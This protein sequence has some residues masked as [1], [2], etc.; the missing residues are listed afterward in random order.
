MTAPTAVSPDGARLS[1]GLLLLA[2]AL[3]PA[4]PSG[5]A[6]G[7]PLRGA[8]GLPCPLCGMTRSVVATVHGNV[9]EALATNPAGVLLVVLAVTVLLAR[10]RPRLR[11]PP[12]AL[13]AAAGALWLWQ[14]ARF[15][16]T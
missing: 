11:L 7:C 13:P 2:G 12:W 1:A 5:L 9:G 15:P 6:V 3:V 8:T 16:A 10:R 14:L 4:L